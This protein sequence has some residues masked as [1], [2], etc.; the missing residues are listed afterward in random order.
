MKVYDRNLILGVRSTRDFVKKFDG[1]CERLG[2]NRSEVIRY[3][4]KRFLN[5]HFNN[6]ENFQRVRKE[7]FWR[8]R[9]TAPKQKNLKKVE[10]TMSQDAVKIIEKAGTL[11]SKD[12]LLETIRKSSSKQFFY[13]QPA[14]SK[15][16][17]VVVTIWLSATFH[18]TCLG[19]WSNARYRS[20]R[21]KHT[22]LSRDHVGA[23]FLGLMSSVH[24]Q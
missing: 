8:A 16:V 10:T 7:M 12:K 20:N 23:F 13:S 4:L 22:Y 18:A 6:S 14:G 24:N 21:T 3:C 5:E 1:L 2:Y 9:R 19:W 15:V 11:I 17:T